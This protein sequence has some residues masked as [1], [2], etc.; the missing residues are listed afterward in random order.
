MSAHAAAEMDQ[1]FAPQSDAGSEPARHRTGYP[2]KGMTDD[3]PTGDD[4]H[5]TDQAE[6]DKIISMGLNITISAS[7]VPFIKKGAFGDV[8]FL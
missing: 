7:A 3:Q 4:P 5:I 6:R 8:L 1:T 2:L